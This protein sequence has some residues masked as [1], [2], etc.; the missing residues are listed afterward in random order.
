MI[1]YH[2]SL[3]AD[4]MFRFLSPMKLF[5]IVLVMFFSA[6]SCV[7]YLFS[8]LVLYSL[9]P[10]IPSPPL[11]SP[12]PPPSLSPSLHSYVFFGWNLVVLILSCTHQACQL[13][14]HSYSCFLPCLSWWWGPMSLQPSSSPF[15]TSSPP[16]TNSLLFL[17]SILLFYA[18]MSGFVSFYLGV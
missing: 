12:P 15:S 11:P 10:L 6:V 3:L 16:P 4:Y 17:V 8:F 13:W 18:L 2:G 7:I 14:Q 9:I 1:F 5:L